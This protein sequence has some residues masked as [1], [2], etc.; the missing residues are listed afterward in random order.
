MAVYR[1]DDR[2]PQIGKN[3]YISDSARVIGDV[4]IGDKC[5]IGHGAIVRGDYGKIIIG[6]G[7]AIEENT[8]LHIRPN[9][10]LELEESYSWQT[11]QIP[12]CYRNWCYYRI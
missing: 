8:T 5:Y 7:S 12:C 10:I 2:I 1:Y 3:V 9:G 4:T 11:N 6:S